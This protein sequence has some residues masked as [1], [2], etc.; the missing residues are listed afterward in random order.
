MGSELKVG[1]RVRDNDPRMTPRTLIV[2][3]IDG[4]RVWLRGNLARQAQTIISRNR[5]FTDGKTRRS[6]W[7]V[8]R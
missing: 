2:D 6:G 7:S 4:E 5:I 8:I 3:R 1:D